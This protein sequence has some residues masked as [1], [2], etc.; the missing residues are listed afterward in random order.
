MILWAMLALALIV[1]FSVIVGMTPSSIERTV[2]APDVARVLYGLD[3][4]ESNGEDQFR[5][6]AAQ[7][8]IAL[9]GFVRPAP[10]VLTIEASATRPEDQPTAV[11]HMAG[12]PPA[13]LSLEVAREWRTYHALVVPTVFT[14]EHQLIRMNSTTFRPGIDADSRELGI[15]VRR[16]QAQQLPATDSARLALVPRALFLALTTMVLMALLWRIGLGWQVVVVAGTLIVLLLGGAQSRAPGSLA[17]W[18]P[19]AWF[20]LGLGTLALAV[21]TARFWRDERLPLPRTPALV[22][23]SVLALLGTS[24]LWLH[25]SPWVGLPLVLAGA[26]IALVGLTPEEYDVTAEWFAG[27]GRLTLIGLLGITAVALVLRLYRINSLPVAFWRDE[28]YHGTQALEIWRNPVYRPIYVPSVDLPAL[29]FYL[30]A[31]VIGTFGPDL[32][33]VRLVPALAGTLTPLAL[34]FALRPMF[35]ARV[36][37]IAAWCM[38]VSAWNLYMSRWGFPVILDPLCVLTAIGCFWRALAPENSRSR[39]AAW[40]AVGGAAAALAVYTYHTGRLAPLVVGLFVLARLWQQR[41]WRRHARV[42]LIGAVAFGLVIAPIVLYALTN[43]DAFSKRLNHVSLFSRPDQEPLAPL[44][45]LQDNIKRYVLMW[46]VRG[47]HNA[48]HYA[49][50]RPMLDPIG[51]VLLL[52]G[53]GAWLV[54][55]RT[56]LGLLVLLWLVIGLIPGIFS[57]VPPHAM[58][59]IGSLAPA[60]TFV[61]LGL[62]ALVLSLAGMSRRLRFTVGTLLVLLAAW[63]VQVYFRTSNDLRETFAAF[64]TTNSL[65]ARGAR[66]VLATTPPSGVPYQPYLAEEVRGQVVTKF[67][68]SETTV[69]YLDG[70][71]FTPPLNGRAILLL[72][73]DLAKERYAV[74]VQALG[75]G[76]SLLRTGPPHPDTNEPIYLVYGTGSDAQWLADRLPLP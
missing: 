50:D 8:G 72:P 45:V 48:R 25:V 76:A 27:A 24:A 43:P 11:L 66:A 51:G 57:D 59:S 36:A 34:W 67:L 75:P 13:D 37:L 52:L 44:S 62:D 53:M 21:E 15:A 64:D 2:T 33:T 70:T 49:P 41:Q 6:S 3:R 71:R 28:V 68:V 10:L 20:L 23:G 5:W 12:G 42:L 61:A 74:A 29:L 35:G 65:L 56:L 46:H 16:V 7:W 4:L 22:G 17:Y 9:F 18:F 40:S 60:C 47:D 19:D 30:I 32:W 54:R 26:A 14:D 58:R 63:N 1:V 69:G 39:A 31:P 38:A 55:R 73:G